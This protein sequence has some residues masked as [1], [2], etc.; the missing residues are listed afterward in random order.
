MDSDLEDPFGDSD[1][2][3]VMNFSELK[4]ID[5]CTNPNLP[6]NNLLCDQSNVER[7][8]TSSTPPIII[9]EPTSS[10]KSPLKH[11]IKLDSNEIGPGDI[12]LLQY[13]NI[14]MKNNVPITQSKFKNWN[15]QNFKETS[16][17]SDDNRNPS[18]FMNLQINVCIVNFLLIK[19]NFSFFT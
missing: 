16:P 18:P 14:Y 11:N 4:L 19:L 17:E 6:N 9:N 7:A 15:I 8:T 3:V 5:S 12:R 1:D 10:R 13:F 2:D